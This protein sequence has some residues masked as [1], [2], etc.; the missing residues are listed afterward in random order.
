MFA[1]KTLP[2]GE[3]RRFTNTANVNR[4]EINLAEGFGE[5]SAVT[6]FNCRKYSYTY[7][8]SITTSKKYFARAETNKTRP[9]EMVYMT[10]QSTKHISAVA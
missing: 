5:F 10:K 2:R 3:L 7:I 1:A 6:F 9:A 4:G 8:G